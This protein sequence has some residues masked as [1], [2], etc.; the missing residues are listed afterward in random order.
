MSDSLSSVLEVRS[1]SGKDV[2]VNLCQTNVFLCSDKKQQD[3]KAQ[4]SPSLRSRSWLRGGRSQWA[5]PS[6]AGSQI[7]S[8][9]HHCGSKAPKI[10]LA[11]RLLRLPTWQEPDPPDCDPCQLSLPLCC[12]GGNEREVHHHLKAWAQP[13]GWP[14]QGLWNP[15]GHSPQPVPWAA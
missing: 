9:C 5:A 15:E 8:S 14:W 6:G 1:W 7:L 3:A 13:S 11:L 12:R 2:P 10:Q 4:L